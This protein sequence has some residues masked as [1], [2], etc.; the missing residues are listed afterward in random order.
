LRSCRAL[1]PLDFPGQ[2][3]T[4]HHR[5]GDVVDGDEREQPGRE[6]HSVALLAG[7]DDLREELEELGG[8]QDRV[9]NRARLDLRLL[10]DL[11]SQVAAVGRAVGA[12]DAHREVVAH[13]GLALGR[14]LVAC[15][16]G[17]EL[18][19]RVVLPCGRVG[20]VDDGIRARQRVRQA[21]AGDDVDAGG[22]RGRHGLMAPL[23]QPL[24]DVAPDA[25]AAADDHDPHAC[26][27]RRASQCPR[28]GREHLAALS[29]MWRSVRLARPRRVRGAP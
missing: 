12:D 2:A 9:R 7:V 5:G 28:R 26:S 17:E 15:R 8:A 25:A 18:Q 14:Q 13:A 20:G 27:S 22:R 4:N 23:A 21:R 19:H 24:D 16:G 6:P 1:I 29:I 3:P 10:R 11:G